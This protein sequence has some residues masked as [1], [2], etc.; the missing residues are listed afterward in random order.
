VTHIFNWTPDYTDAGVY[1]PVTFTVSDG[2]S[3]D[4]ESITITVDN[5]NRKPLISGITPIPSTTI[6]EGESITIVINASD[7]DGDSLTYAVLNEPYGS[8]FI[9]NDFYWVPGYDES[10]EYSDISLTVS[11]GALTS[12]PYLVT[13]TVTNAGDA[14]VFITQPTVVASY[15]VDGEAKDVKVKGDYAYVAY[16]SGGLKTL[17]IADLN[18]IYE[19]DTINNYTNINRVVV[20][21][22]YAYIIDSGVLVEILDISIPSLPYIRSDILEM[23]ALDVAVYS[24]TAYIVCGNDTYLYDITDRDSPQKI[25]GFDLGKSG[26]IIVKDDY[27][28]AVSSD[29]DLKTIDTTTY[30]IIATCTVQGAESYE[31]RD[32]AISGNNAYIAKDDY[33]IV[34]FDIADLSNP[35]QSGQINIA[36]TAIMDIET[37]NRDRIFSIGYKPSDDSYNVIRI[38]SSDPENMIELGSYLFSTGTAVNSLHLDGNRMFIASENGIDV[39]IAQLENTYT[40]EAGSELKITVYAEDP[41]RDTLT[42]A[43]NNKPN[44]TEAIFTDNSDNTATFTWTP[45]EYEMGTYANISFTAADS[46][47]QV[48]SKNITINV[49][50][51]NQPIIGSPRLFLRC[52]GEDGSIAITD[53]SSNN[54]TVTA[55]S[56]AHIDG[57]A[58]KFGTGS[59]ILNGYTDY[60][61][62]P[63]HS[64]FDIQTDFTIELWVRHLVPNQKEAEQYITHFENMQNRWLLFHGK[65]RGIAFIVVSEGEVK[66]HTG[67]GTGGYITDSEWHHVA[68]CKVGTEYGVYKD[69]RQIGY[70][71]SSST[72]NFTGPL[73]IGQRGDDGNL[74]NGNMDEVRLTYGN[75]FNAAPNNRLVD[76]IEI[77]VEEY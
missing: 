70:V 22:N 50:E 31:A 13:V 53:S 3:A 52:N 12:D 77:P 62:I 49:V 71:N 8:G 46:Y 4:E 76:A 75:P 47:Q 37:Y 14:P 30:Q 40:V 64:A 18:N 19:R 74:F 27:A 66:I 20:A 32:I 59:L 57:S 38:D 21:D 10:G 58:S 7:P 11:D 55:Y 61:T 39:V 69:G 2:N 6:A 65:N 28:C 63:D 54:H 35:I 25:E 72:Y 9:D 73:Y 45:T 1:V 16:G 26:R 42:Y 43:M 36:D 34:A 60:S 15:H 51:K 56:S 44:F 68:V 29:E 24:N 33:G 41:D 23:T 5:I 67:Y 17:D 48:Q